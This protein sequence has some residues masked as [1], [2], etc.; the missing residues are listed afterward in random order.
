MICH[1]FVIRITLGNRHG[2]D[3]NTTFHIVQLLMYKN[4][5][6]DDIISCSGFVFIRGIVLDT[7]YYDE[8]EREDIL[9]RYECNRH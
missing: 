1:L 2:I 8:M 3:Y 4:I 6:F 9:N 7:Y 5:L